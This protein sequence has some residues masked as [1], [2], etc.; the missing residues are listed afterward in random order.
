MVKITV[1]VVVMFGNTASE[2]YKLIKG[3]FRLSSSGMGLQTVM[4]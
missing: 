3:Y 1:V 4:P 2:L